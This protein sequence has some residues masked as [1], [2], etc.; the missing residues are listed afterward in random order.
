MLNPNLYEMY[1]NGLKL[2]VVSVLK[3]ILFKI[4]HFFPMNISL[5]I[6][7]QNNTKKH[8]SIEIKFT[9]IQKKKHLY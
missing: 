3:H 5:L 6:I 8:F 2:Q 7:F 9:K 1:K 4:S